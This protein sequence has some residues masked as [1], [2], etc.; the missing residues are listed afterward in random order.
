MPNTIDKA[1]KMKPLINNNLPAVKE[2][3]NVSFTG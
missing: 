3:I 1:N 2:L